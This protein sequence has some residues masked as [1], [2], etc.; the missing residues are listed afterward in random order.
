MDDNL[1]ILGKYALLHLIGNPYNDEL[2]DLKITISQNPFD[3]ANLTVSNTL[4]FGLLKEKKVP[5]GKHLEFKQ[6]FNVVHQLIAEY[7]VAYYI[8]NVFNIDINMKERGYAWFTIPIMEYLLYNIMLLWEDGKF[9]NKSIN[10]FFE[11]EDN[12]LMWYCKSPNNLILADKL[13]DITSF[14]FDLRG[15]GRNV[16]LFSKLVHC[17]S[18]RSLMLFTFYITTRSANALA[19]G[20]NCGGFRNLESFMINQDWKVGKEVNLFASLANCPNLKALI[21]GNCKVTS[22]SAKAL[23]SGMNSNKFLNLKSLLLTSNP[24]IGQEISLFNSLANCPNLTQLGVSRCN[25]TAESLKCFTNGINSGSFQNLEALDFS[26][27]NEVGSSIEFF[28]SL[29]KLAKILDICLSNCNITSASLQSWTRGMKLNKF[30][31]LQKLNISCNESVRKEIAFIYEIANSKN[32]QELIVYNCNLTPDANEAIDV[33]R[34]REC[35]VQ[36]NYEG[37]LVTFS[38]TL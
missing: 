13:Q 11:C 7:L 33:L 32:L 38:V 14:Q 24:E 28:L 10:T 23:A 21:I 6:E 8:A 30:S 4:H 15:L 34:K 29:S 5:T 12:C 35:I 31:N 22:Q 27:N 9:S 37:H 36:D 20:M 25:I 1:K 19:D 17:K 16:N 3:Y 2:K 18:L 26:W